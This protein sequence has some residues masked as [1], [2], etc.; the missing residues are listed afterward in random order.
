MEDTTSPAEIVPSATELAPRVEPV[1]V[2]SAPS[3]DPLAAS[4][5]VRVT[6]HLGASVTLTADVEPGRVAI[7]SGDSVVVP[8]AFWE[9][10]RALYRPTDF[11]DRITA[12]PV[13]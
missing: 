1:V 10:Y 4:V 5:H 6:N 8:A 11:T 12:A 3:V 9:A 13:G 7:R 2:A